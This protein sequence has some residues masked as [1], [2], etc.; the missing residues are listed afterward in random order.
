M[1]LAHA[2]AAPD[3]NTVGAGVETGAEDDLQTTC[4]LCGES[5]H[6]AGPPDPRVF[7]PPEVTVVEDYAFHGEDRVQFEILLALR[8]IAASQAIIAAKP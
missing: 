4:A 8:S 7:P 5:K 1:A 6:T 3:M 2:G